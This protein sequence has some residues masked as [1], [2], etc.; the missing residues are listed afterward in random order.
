MA[1]S[2]KSKNRSRMVLKWS[3]KTILKIT[4]L[5][6]ILSIAQVLILKLI[7][8][9]F[10]VSNSVNWVKSIFL[11]NPYQIPES[12]WRN[13]K[14][15]SPSL[16]RAVLAGEDQRFLIHH[17]FDFIEINNAIKDIFHAKRTRGASTISMQTARTVFLWNSR[18][19]VRKF[20]EAYYTILIEVIWGK[21]RIFE[22][23][24]NLVDWGPGVLGAEAA[25]QKYFN[26]NSIHISSNQA[27]IL[28]AILPSPHK[29]SPLKPDSRV[30]QRQK[31]II[32]DM[33][34][35]PLIL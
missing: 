9:P 26:K 22:V 10:T 13:L 14:K 18:S 24:L 29:W 7:N 28:A 5:L 1:S 30:R 35:M 12:H 31:K 3:L 33:S 20:L 19:L 15:I 23:Y 17:G 2:K 27:A 11:S 4:C 8:P 6:I 25:S 16:K 21:K 34:K 32:Q